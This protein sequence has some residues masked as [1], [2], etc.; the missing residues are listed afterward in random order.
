MTVTLS[1]LR[2]LSTIRSMRPDL[3]SRR[4][5]IK[6]GCPNPAINK[7]L[8]ITGGATQGQSPAVSGVSV[9]SSTD[10]ARHVPAN[11]P[12]AITTGR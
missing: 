1:P 10:P 9:C 11:L 6:D 5:N 7:T 12:V 8:P 4:L 2:E 3:K